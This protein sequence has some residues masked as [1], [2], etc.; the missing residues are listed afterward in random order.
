MFIAPDAES[1]Y[2]I[3]SL[4]LIAFGM[5]VVT[6]MFLRVGNSIFNREELLGRNI[7]DIN[8]A[9]IFQRMW[10]NIRAVDENLTP[11]N[12][13]IDWVRRG[14]PLAVARLGHALWIVPAWFF[15]VFM[16]GVFVAQMPAY[17]IDMPSNV[18]ALRGSE[19]IQYLVDTS[20]QTR[21][22]GFI[23]LN[24]L[25]VLALALLLGVF[26]FGAMSLVAT[27]AVFAILGYLTVRL[28]V[29]G[30]D[31]TIFAAGIFTH[32]IIEIPVIIIATAAALRLGA[33]ITKPPKGHTVGAAWMS[34]LGDTVK[35]WGA[36]VLPG[37]L[38]AA[39]LEAFV[40]PRVLAMLIGG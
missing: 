16:I 23:L 37:L 18:E 21:A 12:G 20:V 38:L 19:A 25:R 34:A 32:G 31:M 4:W 8:L 24:N 30:F 9:S 7:D 2:G 6:V 17:Q 3:M 27:P 11:A 35:I 13:L 1:P 5:L 36:L 10:Q 29:S 40:T 14:V 26:S 22:F 33:A 39:A 28:A 15:V